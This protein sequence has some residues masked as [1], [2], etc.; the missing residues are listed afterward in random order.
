MKNMTRRC[1]P[2]PEPSAKAKQR[3]HSV[4]FERP[5]ARR[6][7]LDWEARLTTVLPWAARAGV[8]RQRLVVSGF[9]VLA[10][11]VGTLAAVSV[12]AIVA[13]QVRYQELGVLDA[14]VT[15]L[16]RRFASPALTGVM[17]ALSVLGE[18]GTLA[19]L[20]SAA[21]VVML[22]ER[23]RV[24]DLLFM[25]TTIVGSM[26]LNTTMK[27]IF[28]RPR[29]Q[30]A[31]ASVL[32]DYSFPSGHS[33]NS[34]ALFMAFALLVGASRGRVA[35]IVASSVALGLALLIGLSRIYL[36]YH[37][38]SDVVGGFAAALIWLAIAWTAFHPSS[39]RHLRPQV[40]EAS[41]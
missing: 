29:P 38:F 6:Q 25:S 32:P 39:E 13:D 20:A 11:Y 37:Y 10:G 16:V 19:G 14:H 1:S 15:P 41:L 28:E 40:S 22:A 5:N 17:T 4:D 3:P 2:Q 23:R 30:L 21:G 36:G 31:W 35:G 12:V 9:K 8:E 18:N 34:L 27:L 33:M 24:T 7:G 26:C